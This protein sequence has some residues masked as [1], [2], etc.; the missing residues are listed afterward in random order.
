MHAYFHQW[1]QLLKI[2]TKTDSQDLECFQNKNIKTR[3]LTILATKYKL[4]L[5]RESNKYL[6]LAWFWFKSY[7]IRQYINKIL[8]K[9]RISQPQQE[10]ASNAASTF[11]LFI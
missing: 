10:I 2:Y 9:N 11:C 6:V 4:T 8:R 3:Y 5:H 7:T 1:L